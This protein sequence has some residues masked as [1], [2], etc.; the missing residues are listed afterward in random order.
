MSLETFLILSA[1]TLS[2]VDKLTVYQGLGDNCT[3][4]LGR[5]RSGVASYIPQPE[6]MQSNGS[7]PAESRGAMGEP[8]C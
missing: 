4:S 6:A 2:R 5:M 1:K 3:G 7:T 8:T